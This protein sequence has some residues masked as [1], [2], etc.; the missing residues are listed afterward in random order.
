[1]S[2]EVKKKNK[3]MF[4]NDSYGRGIPTLLSKSNDDVSVFGEV[5][6]GAKVKDVLKNCYLEGTEPIVLNPQP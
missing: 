1:L 4:Y 6:P 2:K 5:R 3:L